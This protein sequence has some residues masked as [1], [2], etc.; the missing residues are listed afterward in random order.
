MFRS[1]PLILVAVMVCFSVMPLY[2]TNVFADGI[3]EVIKRLNQIQKTLDDQVIP[4]LDE[5]T[6]CPECPTCTVGVPKTGQTITYGF[7]DDGAL[8]KG[9]PW[10]D[11]RFTDNGDG[12]VTD[13]LTGLIWLKNANCF[14]Q[15]TWAEA[16]N[17]CN[18]L[19]SGTCEL[20]DGSVAGDWRL[21]NV[22][23]ISSLIDFSQFGPALSVGHPFANV[24]SDYYWSS[25]SKDAVGNAWNVNMSDGG[26]GGHYKTFVDYVWPVRDA[27][28]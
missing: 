19:A 16:L 27:K 17:D 26:V 14:E 15:K 6:Q 8:Q 11:P 18:T 4:K 9:V 24:Q 7:R 20:N 28:K 13:K 5:C 10:P 1:K 12:T 22:R 21:A 3:P 2:P 23:E 25:T